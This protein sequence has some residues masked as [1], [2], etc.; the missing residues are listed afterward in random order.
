MYF[1][2]EKLCDV[3]SDVLLE[4]VSSTKTKSLLYLTEERFIELLLRKVNQGY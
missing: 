4:F 2:F 3:I 1:N